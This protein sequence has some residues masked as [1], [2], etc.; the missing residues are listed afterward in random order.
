MDDDKKEDRAE[1]EEYCDNGSNAVGNRVGSIWIAIWNVAGSGG[2][3][4]KHHVTKLIVIVM[5]ACSYSYF[6]V[7]RS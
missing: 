7:L 4:V 1:L 6:I 5:F 3:L 2:H